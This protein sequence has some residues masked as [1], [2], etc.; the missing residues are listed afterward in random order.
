MCIFCKII[1]KEIPSYAIYEDEY[2]YA[3][4][5]NC[6]DAIGHTLVV[7]KQHC[8]N[9]LDCPIELLGKVTE[10]VHKIAK[11]YVDDCG[12]QGVNI[13][14]ASGQCAQQSVFHLHIHLVPRKAGDNINM[15]P[16]N[17]RQEMNLSTVCQQ[18]QLK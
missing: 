3:F 12:Y 16:D 5:D 13:L 1:S 7:P 2:T 14:N 8:V 6:Q 11:H 9:L 17:A 10:T 18:L 4:L 15:W